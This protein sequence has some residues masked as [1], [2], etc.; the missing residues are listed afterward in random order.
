MY[1]SARHSNGEQHPLT[2]MTLKLIEN[3]FMDTTE[4]TV[5]NSDHT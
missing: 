4:D 5:G 3:A 1:P 2:K